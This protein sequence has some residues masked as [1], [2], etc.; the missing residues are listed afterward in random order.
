LFEAGDIAHYI[1]ASGTGGIPVIAN[2][3]F[4]WKIDFGLLTFD[5]NPGKEMIEWLRK[6]VFAQR[7]P[8]FL[9]KVRLF[10]GFTEIED[11]FST[12]DFKRYILKQRIGITE[13][14]SV[15]IE[16]NNISRILLA[17]GFCSLAQQEGLKKE[18]FDDDT[19]SNFER[20]FQMIHEMVDC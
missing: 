6:T 5:N 12:L 4:G 10:D 17:S 13:K 20:L 1:P 2:L 15:F 11:L 19:R 3:L 9:K 8:A 18:D 14:N 7:E 16:V